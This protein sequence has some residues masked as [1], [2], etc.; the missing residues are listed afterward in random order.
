MRTSSHISLRKL[1][2][3]AVLALENSIRLH[4]DSI[5]LFKNGSFPSA[6]QLSVLAF[7]ELG[8][9]KALDNFIWNTVTHKNKR[10]YEEELRYI[11]LLYIHPW[12]QGA[13]LLRQPYNFSKKFVQSIERKELENKKQRAIYVGLQRKHGKI[14]IKG[15]ISSPWMIKEKDARQQISLLNDIF[16]EIIVKA[17][18][19]GMYFD[20]RGMDKLMT[21][22]LK[23]KLQ[24]WTNRSGIKKRR[25]LVFRQSPPAP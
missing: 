24:I 2:K 13:G 16:L 11:E 3:M 15:R 20:I 22:S 1:E 23:K 4:L 21:S 10:N 14:D 6:F 18:Y 25:K 19:Q 9:S 12:K 5:L 8:K 7:E 17:D